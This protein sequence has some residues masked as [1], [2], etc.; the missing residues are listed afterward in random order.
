VAR[1]CA[2]IARAL[3]GL[4]LAGAGLVVGLVS[5]RL[6]RGPIALD[7]LTPYLEQALRPV[8]GSVTVTLQTTE[9]AWEWRRRRIDLHVHGVRVLAPSGETVA[10]LPMLGLRLSVRA[11]LRG[12][13]APREI[14]VFGPHLRLVRQPGG[15][16][17]LDLGREPAAEG[18]SA[19]SGELLR[20]LAGGRDS[21]SP[22]RWLKAVRTTEATMTIVDRE[23]AAVW[24]VREVEL[25]L[26]R[27]AT[28][29]TASAA[30]VVA[31]GEALVPIRADGRLRDERALEVDVT[32]ARL[33]TGALV[34]YWPEDA[35]AGVRRWIT[36]N[37]TSGEVH[38]AAVRLRATLGDGEGRAFTVD[39]VTG[40]LA[41]DGLAVRYLESMPAVTGV[42]G[43]ATFSGAAWD[44]RVARGALA[45]LELVRGTVGIS[46]T[47][48]GGP[49]IAIDAEVRGPL[50]RALAVLDA[51]PIGLGRTLGIAPTEISGSMTTHLRLAFPLGRTLRFEDLG[52]EA[53]ARLG[54]VATARLPRSWSLAGGD[55]SLELREQTL[56]VTGTGRL[57]DEPIALAWHEDLSRDLTLKRRLEV[58]ARLDTAGRAALGFPTSPWLDGPIDA[59]ARFTQ[60]RGQGSDGTLGLTLDL[61]PAALNLPALGLAKPAG[62]A[63][64][65]EARLV[66]TAGAVTGVEAFTLEVGGSAIRGR[67]GLSRDG[68]TLRTLDAEA[69]IAP[70][71]PAEKP[72]HFTAVLRPAAAASTVTITS[73]DAGALFRALG[74]YADADGGRAVFNGTLDLAAAG[75]PFAGRLDIRNC[76]LTRSPLLARIAT[77]ASLPGITSALAGRGI[78][79]DLVTAT[80]SKQGETV[81]IANGLMTGPSLRMLLAGTI[82]RGHATG[83]FKGTLVP[84]YYGLNVAPGR[85]PLIGGLL[86]G[87]DKEGLYAIDFEMTGPLAD[88]H[89]SVKPLSVIA[90]GALRE[91]MRRLP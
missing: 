41:F 39:A 47:G 2:R 64:R 42:A 70:P 36:S 4:T 8:D 86:A 16:L 79:L 52:L 6:A 9:L 61:E 35:A 11:L 82:D 12:I 62:A 83:A 67:A 80:L 73:D 7:F 90:P 27:D 45:G 18:A 37:I 68:T 46:E 26:Q 88:P 13:V 69:T 24:E 57:Q 21:D 44:F 14:E 76:T 29:V 89:V 85:L 17:D 3:V 77:L 43:R 30:G 59:Q 87:K 84:S 56:D 75:S 66:M 34:R 50:A 33:P 48:T 19:W 38:E 65:A 63:G 58:S 31:V 72:G 91:L 15:G 40:R 71:S 10:E 81:T 23:N 51:N 53:S 49:R 28:G 1:R 20:D 78:A 54:D 60:A 74:F 32:V 5:W 55:L 22:A 25:E